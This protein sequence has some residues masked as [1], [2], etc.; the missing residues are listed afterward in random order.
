M[1]VLPIEIDP[2]TIDIS[3]RLT[4]A[5]AREH[6]LTSYDAA[7]LELALRR[8]LRLATKD[9]ALARAAAKSAVDVIE[10]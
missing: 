6:K 9:K 2:I 3:W 5:L 4:L 10:I 8:G 7:Y 1:Q